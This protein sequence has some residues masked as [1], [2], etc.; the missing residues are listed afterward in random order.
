MRVILCIFVRENGLDRCE[1]WGTTCRS[2]RI[3]KDWNQAS[4]ISV[5][6]QAAAAYRAVSASSMSIISKPHTHNLS[7][8][9]V[10]WRRETKATGHPQRPQGS[11]PISLPESYTRIFFR[12]GPCRIPWKNLGKSPR[13]GAL[14]IVSRILSPNE[15]EANIT[16]A[17]PCAQMHKPVYN[18]ESVCCPSPIG[19]Q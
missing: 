19:T 15:S 12:P 7:A 16:E 17:N 11:F 13:P 2:L 3:G 4:G 1:T 6:L 5:G 9:L 14:E 10:L 8:S 18:T